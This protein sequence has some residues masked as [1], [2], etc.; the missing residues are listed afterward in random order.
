[1]QLLIVFTVCCFLSTTAYS[2]DNIWPS[3]VWSQ[4]EPA[5]LAVDPI[6]LK[7]FEKYAFSEE[8]DFKSDSLL[9][10]YKGHIIFERY[11]PNFDRQKSHRLWSITKSVSIALIGIALKESLLS[12][13]DLPKLDFPQLENS[14]FTKAPLKVLDLTRMSSGLDWNE[15]YEGNPLGSDV[16]KMLYTE[17]YKDMASYTASRPIKYPAGTRFNYSS[18]ETNLMM[19]VLK[20]RI[21]NQKKYNNYPWN[22]LFRILNINS[23]VWEQDA[24]GTFVGSSYLYMTARDLARF[25]YLFLRKGMWSAYNVL[26]YQWV[27]RFTAKLAPSVELTH[28]KGDDRRSSYGAHWWLNRD[29][30][31]KKEKRR[32]P[33]IPKT[34]YFGLGHHG[35]KLAIL[36]SH[37][38]VMVRFASDKKGSIDF[39]K[40]ISLLLKAVPAI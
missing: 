30:P 36:P 15:G 19:A 31:L 13:N 10:A 5:Q 32:Y 26:P 24:S 11:A 3:P 33:S 23:A 9:V 12:L 1:M 37:D 28:K 14:P 6:K 18:G 21:G 17:G 27:S 7:A 8:E 4:K 34:A 40:L 2:N 25:G 39:D 35:Q 22:K 38:L 16:I 29:L 20:A